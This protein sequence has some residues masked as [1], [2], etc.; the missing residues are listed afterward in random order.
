MVLLGPSLFL[1][2]FCGYKHCLRPLRI[3]GRAEVYSTL[4]RGFEI[5][6]KRLDNDKM[7]EGCKR[8]VDTV[9]GA[10]GGGEVDEERSKKVLE[11]RV[12]LQKHDSSTAIFR[13]S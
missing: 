8:G 7:E 6:E 9:G 2:L 13:P 12:G 5:L 10:E 11:M 1:R 4:V 3:L